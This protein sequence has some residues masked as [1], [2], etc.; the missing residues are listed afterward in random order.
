MDGN[1][2]FDRYLRVVL[3]S[4]STNQISLQNR[5]DYNPDVIML[6]M[7]TQST[8]NVVVRTSRTHPYN[9]NWVKNAH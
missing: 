6:V 8:K 1:V 4:T 3:Y 2:D 5:G 7:Y 9:K